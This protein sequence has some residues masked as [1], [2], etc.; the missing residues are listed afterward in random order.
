MRGRSPIRTRR[1]ADDGRRGHDADRDRRRLPRLQ[2]E[3]RACPFV[4]VYRVSVEI[5]ERRPA[6]QQQ[7]GP[8]RRPPG[9]R[10]RVDRARSSPTRRPRPRR[11][12]GRRARPS[13]TTGER[14]RAAQP[15]A[16]QDR[17][18][19]AR[20][21]DLPGPLPLLVRPQVPRDHPRRGRAGA[22]GL[23]LRRPDDG[24]TARCR[25]T[26][27]FAARSR[28]GPERLLPGADRVRRHQQHLRHRDAD[29]RAHQPRAASATPSP[30]AAPRST[31]RSRRSSRC[32]ADLQAG[33]ARCCVEPDTRLERFFPELARRGADRRPGRRAAGRAVHQRGDRLRRDLRPTRR[34]SRRRSP[35]APPT[36]E[37]GIDAA[38]RASAP[39]LRDFA[40]PVARAAPGRHATCGRRCRC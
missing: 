39:F 19:A 17:R 35:R 2:R 37:T 33:G 18:A 23:H 11:P 31:T 21:L 30:A 15:E 27:R 6:D 40:T 14:G 25:P 16:R 1:L 34:R 32:S 3:Q 8:D 20:G 5:P 12:S 13:A 24:A 36:L 28:R 9:R 38:A 10:G 22:R 7:R 29:Q 4:P 26:R